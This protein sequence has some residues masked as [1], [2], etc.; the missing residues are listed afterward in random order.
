MASVAFSLSLGETGSVAMLFSRLAQSLVRGT[1]WLVEP[2]FSLLQDERG[3]NTGRDLYLWYSND[4]P[5]YPNATSP[6][7]LPRIFSL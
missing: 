7:Q 3:R 2:I 5:T 6:S 4:S 1:S